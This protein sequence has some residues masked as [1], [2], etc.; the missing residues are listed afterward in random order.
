MNAARRKRIR[1]AVE[2]EKAVG[3]N[4]IGG[5]KQKSRWLELEKKTGGIR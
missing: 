3:W 5:M 4:G 2:C 1:E